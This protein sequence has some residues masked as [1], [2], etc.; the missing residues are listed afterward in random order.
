MTNTTDKG[1]IYIDCTGQVGGGTL[2]DK[3]LN[4]VKNSPLT[5]SY[6][7]RDGNVQM[8]CNAGSALIY[9]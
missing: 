8:G 4:Y 5:G 9:W 7:F 2:L 3:E 6:L 1:I